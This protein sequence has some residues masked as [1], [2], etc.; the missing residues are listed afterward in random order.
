M[1]RIRAKYLTVTL[2]DKF[3]CC[4]LYSL[5]KNTVNS[6]IFQSDWTKQQTVNVPLYAEEYPWDKI[7]TGTCIQPTASVV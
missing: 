4:V 5:Q 7:K 2:H 3:L 6:K 1:C